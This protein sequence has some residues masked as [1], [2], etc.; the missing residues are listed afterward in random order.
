MGSFRPVGIDRGDIQYGDQSPINIEDGGAR[1]AEIYVPRSVM[2]ASVDCDG[3]LFGDAGA[4]AIR[5]LDR[6]GPYAAEP[7]APVLEEGRIRIIAAMLDGDTC[8]VTE[9]DSVPCFANNLV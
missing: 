8:G 6:L 5:S 4:D 7:G 2:L 9:Q 1:T 3:P